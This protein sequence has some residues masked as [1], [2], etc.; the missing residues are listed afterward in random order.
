MSRMTQMPGAARFE[1]QIDLNVVT[2]Y[3]RTKIIFASVVVSMVI[4]KAIC[5]ERLIVLLLHFEFEPRGFKI[6]S[7]Q[8]S[9][10]RELLLKKSS[11]RLITVI[12][13]GGQI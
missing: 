8:V 2:S 9:M 7:S 3:I 10:Q 12:V 4:R 13:P 11:R 6:Q 5:A 1:W